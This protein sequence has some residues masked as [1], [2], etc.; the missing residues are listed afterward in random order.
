[1]M[2]LWAFLSARGFLGLARGFWVAIAAGL[3]V[4]VA[5]QV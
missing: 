4:V 1:M 3:I 5:V 2:M